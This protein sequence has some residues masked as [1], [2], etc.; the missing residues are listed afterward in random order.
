M[1]MSEFFLS[2]N[3]LPDPDD[4]TIRLLESKEGYEDELTTLRMSGPS[5]ECQI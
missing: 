5:F 2:S 1:R 4:Y 3:F